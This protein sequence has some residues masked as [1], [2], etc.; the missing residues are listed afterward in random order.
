MMILGRIVAGLGVGVL[1]MVVPIYNAE[2]APSTHRGRLVS[3]NQLAI[4]AGIMVS[5]LADLVGAM[6]REG[7]RVALGVQ[8]L[9]GLV[10]VAGTVF[11]PET[12][13]WLTKKRRNEEAVRTLA[14]VR[15]A[16]AS[17]VV[18]ELAEIKASLRDSSS[19]GPS[20]TCQLLLQRLLIGILLQLFQQFTGMNVIMYYSTSIFSRIGVASYISTAVVGALNFL[21][22]ILSILLV[23]KVGRKALLLLGGAGMLVSMAGAAT[24]LLVFRVEEEVEGGSV[25]GY[26]TVVLI[27][28]FVFN[29]AYGWGSIAWVVTSEIYPLHIRGL[30]VSITTT[31][32]WTGNFLVALATPIL[33]GSALH[34][35]GTFYLL[36]GFILLATLFV[37]FSLPETKGESLERIDKLFSKPWLERIDL[38]YYLRLGCPWGRRR[39]GSYNTARGSELQHRSGDTTVLLTDTDAENEP[40]EAKE[41]SF[42]VRTPQPRRN[43]TERKQL[44]HTTQILQF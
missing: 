19:L 31:A 14:K 4:T 15:S 23:D 16:S 22:T 41:A 2:L 35:Y 30:A 10:L 40:E 6:Y 34:T 28:F 37:L 29:F 42:I 36:S 24:V 25:A 3:L 12:P 9:F 26:V 13:R 21:T 43:S 32:N 20:Q 7:W 8:C 38:L 17:E 11:L 1:S 39:Q 5:F 18:P 27:C 44:N 33:L